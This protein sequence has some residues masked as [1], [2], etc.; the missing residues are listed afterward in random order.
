[1]S[2]SISNSTTV[3]AQDVAKREI[4]AELIFYELITT[5]NYHTDGNLTS[6]VLV[7]SLSKAYSCHLYWLYLNWVTFL[8]CEIT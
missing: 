7:L 3:Y 8:L 6:C 4:L 5:F 1:M 2:R